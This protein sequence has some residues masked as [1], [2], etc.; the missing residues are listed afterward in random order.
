[1]DLIPYTD[2]MTQAQQAA[3][4]SEYAL[5]RKDPTTALLLSFFLGGVGAHK[6]YVGQDRQGLLRILFCWTLIPSVLGIVEAPLT[7][8]R[9][10]EHNRRLA[11]T[12][13]Q[14]VRVR[15]RDLSARPQGA[16]VFPESAPLL[17]APPATE[18]ERP[19]QRITT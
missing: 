3:F 4:Y 7:P 13:A 2:G 6:Y 19:A 14:K 12:L 9:V 16:F 11:E 10:R 15:V 17:S 18:A 8:R 5:Q 1:M